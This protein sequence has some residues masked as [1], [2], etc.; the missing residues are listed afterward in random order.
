MPDWLVV[1]VLGIVEGITEFIPVSSTGHLLLTEHFLAGAARWRGNELFNIVIQSAAVVA[2]VPLFRERLRR[3]RHWSDPA[4]RDYLLKV[5]AAF[6]ITGVGG[7]VLKKLGYELPERALPVAG[8]LLLGGILFILVEGWLRGAVTRDEITWT[9]AVAVAG[10]QLVAAIFPGTSRS[11]ATILVALL[12]GT[13][14]PAAT[15][16]SFIVGVPTMLAAGALEI[17]Q[18]VREGT[19][20][21]W[22]LILVAATVSAAVSFLAVRW[23]LHFIQTHTFAGFGWYRV[24]VGTVL[25]VVLLV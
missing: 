4:G 2:V 3:L 18:A 22:L 17:L 10:G 19:S 8:A 11:G 25:F 1:V 23:L 9:V 16:Y 12:L 5:A 13:S 15:E 7:L 24:A 14:R 20:Q 6:A 21:P